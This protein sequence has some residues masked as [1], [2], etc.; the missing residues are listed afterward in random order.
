MNKN[1]RV[2][3]NESTETW[4]A[5]PEVAKGRG[6]GKSK[7]ARKAVAG[8]ALVAAGR[9]VLVCS[10]RHGGVDYQLRPDELR[11]F[12]EWTQWLEWAVV[13]R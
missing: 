3:W 1:Y 5:V 10:D 7:A 11:E 6:K 12:F 2:V 13:H 4:V 9:H 8:G